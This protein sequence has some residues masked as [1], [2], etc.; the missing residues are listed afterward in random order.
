MITEPEF[1]SDVWG[2]MHMAWGVKDDYKEPLYY[3]AFSKCD[4]QM[5]INS[6]KRLVAKSKYFPK[7]SEIYG[8]YN[9]LK[10]NRSSKRVAKMHHTDC[11]NCEGSG[12]AQ[13]W[14][15]KESTAY[16]YVCTCTCHAGTVIRETVKDAKSMTEVQVLDRAAQFGMENTYPGYE[17]PECE[18]DENYKKAFTKLYELAITKAG[19]P[20]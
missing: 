19:K 2:M 13:F 15:W 16:S 3:E 9:E 4:K 5:L 1:K 8:E 12:M 11:P 17:Q 18:P 7:I 20:L 10:R 14:H 6:V